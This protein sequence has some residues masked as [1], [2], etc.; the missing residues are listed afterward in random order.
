MIITDWMV[1]AKMDFCLEI[2]RQRRHVMLEIK[3]I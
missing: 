2:V 1:D 3:V